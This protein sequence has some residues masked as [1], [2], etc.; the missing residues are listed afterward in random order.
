MQILNLCTF[1]PSRLNSRIKAAI[2][3]EDTSM[4]ISL[5]KRQAVSPVI[6]TL[7]LI[8]IAVAAAIIVYA[9]V[10]GLIGGLTN[11]ASSNLVTATASLTVTSGNG[12]GLLVVTI[13][14][15]AN[16]PITGIQVQYTS[17]TDTAFAA[18]TCMGQTTTGA[19]G[20]NGLVGVAACGAV[21]AASATQPVIFCN[22]TPA[23]VE[24]ATP[25]A[26]GGEVSASENVLGTAGASLLSGQSYSMTVTVDFA[27]GGTHSQALSATAQI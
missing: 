18:V 26:V 4:K 8:A 15:T 25:L 19:A 21:N 13:Q 11:G 27:N 9:F 24:T 5:K 6:A 22:S 3:S 23:A 2:L 16:N 7:L 10:T 17:F 1:C 14:N 20:C 12:A